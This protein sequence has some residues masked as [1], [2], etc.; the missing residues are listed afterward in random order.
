MSDRQCCQLLQRYRTDGRWVWLSSNYL[1]PECL[2]E[3]TIQIICKRYSDVG[4]TLACEKLAEPSGVMLSKETV[5]KLVMLSSLGARAYSVCRESSRRAID[6][7]SD[8]RWFEERGPAC[9]LLVYMDDATSRLMQLY[10]VRSDSTLTYLEA[11]RDS[12]DWS[13]PAY[14]SKQSDDDSMIGLVQKTDIADITVC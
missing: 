5:S 7:L 3:R 4:P 10:F 14:S 12:L 13:M 1:L 2:A 9:M 11:M 8:H 6:E